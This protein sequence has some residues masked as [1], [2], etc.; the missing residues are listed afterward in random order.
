M[1]F[2][3]DETVIEEAIVKKVKYNY[4]VRNNQKLI[5]GIILRM[6]TNSLLGAEVFFFG[7]A[8]GMIYLNITFINIFL[9]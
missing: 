6:P 7:L 2:E 1:Q 8:T 3:E 4:R 5:V 9:L